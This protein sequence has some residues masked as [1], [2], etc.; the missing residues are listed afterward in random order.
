MILVYV[1]QI[2]N[3]KAALFMSKFNTITSMV[4]MV[5]TILFVRTLTSRQLLNSILVVIAFFLFGGLVGTTL[6]SDY[7][8]ILQEVTM[9]SFDFY[10]AKTSFMW[11]FFDGFLVIFA[12][13][14]LLGYIIKQTLFLEKDHRRTLVTMIVGVIIAYFVSIIIYVIRKAIFAITDEIVMLHM[15][16]IS[17][18]IGA[19]IMSLSIYL[20]SVE[21]FYYSSEINS[22]YIYNK[23]GYVIYSLSLQ[24]KSSL[25]GMMIPS[26][27]RAFSSFTGELIGKEVFPKQIDLG[28]YSL[29]IEEY[30][31]FICLVSCKNPTAYIKQGVK[32]IL[33]DLSP[34]MTDEEMTLLIENYLAL[35]TK[36]SD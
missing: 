29:I 2:Y 36:H 30:E 35:K 6:S 12:G 8:V 13:S 25:E 28:V 22:L 1:S 21:A 11:L 3:E 26:I 19:L 24:K 31:D 15:E 34:N 5:A 16:L 18:A 7:T 32:N 10:I 14:V 20:G 33:A 9:G 17:V 27:T 4:A 23:D